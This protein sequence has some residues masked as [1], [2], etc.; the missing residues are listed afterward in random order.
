VNNDLDIVAQ[1]STALLGKQAATVL[2]AVIACA[3]GVIAYYQV[4]AAG[5]TT[6]PKTG[7]VSS[8]S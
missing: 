1:D 6:D 5:M 4:L 8:E 2:T 7:T 3:K